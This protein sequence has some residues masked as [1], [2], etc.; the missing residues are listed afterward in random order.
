MSRPKQ[1][2]HKGS[3]EWI[4]TTLERIGATLDQTDNFVVCDAPS[5]YVWRSNGNTSLTIQYRNNC[6]QSWLSQAVRDELPN[7]RMGLLKITDQ[8]RIAEIRY[9]LDDDLWGA[10]TDAPDRIAW[11]EAGKP[12][13]QAAKEKPICQTH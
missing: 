1:G 7:L 10:P 4:R 2:A 8:T 9:A 5:G 11:P 6:G 3:L 13:K 12:T